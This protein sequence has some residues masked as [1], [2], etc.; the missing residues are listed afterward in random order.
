MRISTLFFH[1]RGLSSILDQQAKVSQIQEQV[2]SGRRI[3]K[4]SDDPSGA[5]QIIRLN[6]VIEQTK[7][8]QRNSDI[9]TNRLSLEESTLGNIE[10]SLLRVREIAIQANNSTLSNNDRAALAQEVRER[11]NELIGL[12]NTRDANGEYLFAGL[13]VTTQPFSKQANGS[14]SYSGDQGQRFLNIA[15]GRQMADSDSGAAVFM[16]VDNGNG[17][18]QVQDNPANTG[19][20]IINPGK[21]TDPGSYV[22]D[23]YTITFVTNGNGN[24]AYNVVGASS[25]QIIPP[26]PQ[27]PVTNAPDF[28]SE[29]AITFNGLETSIAGSPVAGDTF[30]VSPSGKQDIFATVNNLATVLETSAF[31]AAGE[32]RISNQVTRVLVDIDQAFSNIIEFRTSVGARLKS[33]EDQ[34]AVND[35]FLIDMQSTLSEVRDLDMTEAIT[36]LQQRLLALQAAQASFSRIQNLSLFQFL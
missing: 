8:F 20:G 1:Q 33:I 18:F 36:V 14:V 11:L 10:T 23:T 3:V 25:G 2:A 31:N 22:A 7:Q 17:T 4:P 16:D 32:A 30:T 21:V 29:A 24:L 35:S 28:S 6:Q 26:L 34:Q 13:R 27:N 15:S 19:A 12:A 5:S 9:I